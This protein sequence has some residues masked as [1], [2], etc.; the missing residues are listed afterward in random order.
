MMM[1]RYG[2]TSKPQHLGA[3]SMS[4][5]THLGVVRDCRIIN[6][7][8]CYDIKVRYDRETNC[9]IGEH[10]LEFNTVDGEIVDPFDCFKP[11]YLDLDNLIPIKEGK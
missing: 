9:W 10:N 11:I 8:F 3:S 2:L 5:Y 6:L 4:S 7:P 1:Q